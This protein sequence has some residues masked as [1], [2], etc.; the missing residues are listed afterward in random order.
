MFESYNK[1]DF[2]PP[3]KFSRSNQLKLKMYFFFDRIRLSVNLLAAALI[4]SLLL[5]PGCGGQSKDT[6][7]GPPIPDT[8]KTYTGTGTPIRIFG[9]GGRR[10]R[11]GADDP[12]YQE[13][14]LWKE[15]KEYQRYKE[16][17]ESQGR[18]NLNSGQTENE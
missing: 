16:F 9:A 5:L 17:L 2:Q 13:Y 15:W 10:A 3:Y 7:P 1:H 4:G 14:L 12:E 8:P 11:P 18:D 6:P